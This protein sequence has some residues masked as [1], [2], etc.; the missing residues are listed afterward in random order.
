MSSIPD[1]KGHAKRDAP[2]RRCPG[3]AWHCV[4]SV[5]VGRSHIAHHSIAISVRVYVA[6]R[7]LHE[8]AAG[9]KSATGPLS[10]QTMDLRC[11]QCTARRAEHRHMTPS[12]SLDMLRP[13]ESCSELLLDHFHSRKC[14]RLASAAAD[15]SPHWCAQQPLDGQLSAAADG[16][17]RRDSSASRALPW[18]ST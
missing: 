3:Q 13:S 1:T 18:G 11:A 5:T 2:Q 6:T 8:R 12:Q 17:L 14:C 15:T 7:E 16:R 10:G 4:G 9:C